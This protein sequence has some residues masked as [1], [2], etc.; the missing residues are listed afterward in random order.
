MKSTNYSIGGGEGESGPDF[1]L[2][3]IHI[4]SLLPI[5]ENLDASIVFAPLLFHL[6]LR[7]EPKRVRLPLH[8]LF[9]LNLRL[10]LHCPPAFPR[11]TSFYKDHFRLPTHNSLSLLT[12]RP[13]DLPTSLLTTQTNCCSHAHR[14]TNLPTILPTTTPPT[15]FSHNCSTISPG[16]LLSS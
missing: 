7:L 15:Y 14:I 5:H 1:W 3:S 10:N 2:Q 8:F 11:F 13:S 9:L 6:K 16:F 4:Q 12:S